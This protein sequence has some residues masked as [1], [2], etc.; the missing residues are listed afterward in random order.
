VVVNKMP[1]AQAAQES[2]T[3]YDKAQAAA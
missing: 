2:A 1:V 3:R